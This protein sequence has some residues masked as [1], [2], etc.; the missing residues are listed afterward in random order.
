VYISG[1]LALKLNSVYESNFYSYYATFSNKDTVTD[2]FDKY[3]VMY[4]NG[5]EDF[6]FLWNIIQAKILKIII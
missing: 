6:I 2:Y 4:V 1:I 5:F 3:F